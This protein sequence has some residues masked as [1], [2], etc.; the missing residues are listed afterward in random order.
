MKI[1]VMPAQAEQLHP[2]CPR[3]ILGLDPGTGIHA[4]G[5]WIPA[6]AGMTKMCGNDVKRD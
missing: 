3:V 1:G 6:F 2:S 4:V 5:V